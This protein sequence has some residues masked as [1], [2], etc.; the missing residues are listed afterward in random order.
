MSLRYFLFLL[1]LL[2]FPFVVFTQPESGDI[3]KDFV[4]VPEGE[5]TPITPVHFS[6]LDPNTKRN[7]SDEHAWARN[8]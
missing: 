8:K 6:E 7:F 1:L 3:F 4:F 2:F 5:P